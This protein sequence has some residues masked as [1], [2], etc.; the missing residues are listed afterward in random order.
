MADKRAVGHAYN[1]DFLNV[2]F[3][4]SSLFVLFT[5]V[6]MVWDDYDR[7]WKNHQREFAQ[8][9]MEVTRLNLGR[10]QQ[11]VDQARL[12]ELTA[13]RAAAEEQAAASAGQVADLETQLAE[14]NRQLFVATQ[15]YQ[16]TKANYDVDRY[17]FEVRRE[18]AH[19]EHPEDDGEEVVV[20]GEEE[21]T[22]LYEEWL[23][24]GLDVESLTASRDD[25]RRQIGAFAEGVSAI[26][27]E[28]GGLT[29]EMERLQGQVTD[30]QP[31]LVADYLLN[32]PLLDFMAP[33]L[34]VRQVIT[35]NIVD[36]VNFVRVAKMDRCETCHLAIDRVGYEDYPQ[37]F[38]THPELDAYVGSGSP[39]PLESTGCTVCH[40]GMGQS[41]SF[42][43]AAH[44]PAT[45]EQMALWEDEYDWEESHLWDFPMLPTGMAEASCAKCHKEELFVPGADNLNLAY[46]MYERAGCYAC[47]KTRGFEDLRK[48][49]PNLTKLASK[50][51]EE[52]VANWIRDPRAVKASTW[53][54]RVWYNSN[55]DAAEDAVRNEVEIDAV[56]AYLFAN[57]EDHEMAV[58]NP[59]R[60]DAENG[61]R[62]VD[63]VGCLACHITG[64]EGREAAG[65]RRTF[66]Q[67]LQAVGSKT[68]FEWL[69]DWVRDPRH[70]SAETYMPDLRLT[71][72]EIADVATYLAS[73]T[74]GAGMT[75]GAGYQAADVDAVLLDYMRAVVPSEEAQ[76]T[77]AAMS[78]EERQ[79]DLGQRAIGR[80]GCYSCHEISGFE[81]TQAIGTELSEEGSKLLPQFDFAF[82]HDIPHSKRD[83]IKAKLIDPRT[84][85]QNRILQPLEKLRMPDFGFSEEEA[86][87]LTTAVMSFQRDVQPKIAQVPRSARKDATIDGRNLLRRRNCVGC[88]EMEGDGGDYRELVEDPSL[89]PPL[90]TPEGA[91]VQADWLYDFFRGPITIRPWLDVRMPTFGLDDAHWNDFLDYFA[92]VSDV[93]GPF[94]THEAV[95]S[96]GDLRTGEELFELLRCQQCHVLD[97]IPED[98]EV[99]NLAPDLRMAPERLQPEWILNWLIDPLVIQPGT[100]MPG[101]WTEYPGS[102]YPQFDQDGPAQIQSIRDY[103]LTFSGGPSP[104]RGN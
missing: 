27:D 83:W 40:E 68:S 46:G 95:P 92:A 80:Y 70:Y 23:A 66:G 42:V 44:T 72:A 45:D 54:P 12:G 79:L 34:T 20:P 22:A 97:T 75:A 99:S 31:S 84:Y 43:D 17:A 56:V 90:L 2:V 71:D 16:F 89:A 77:L 100:R 96:A 59:R 41:I 9:E 81:D 101:F 49:G 7:E 14:V 32:A 24:L 15:R 18:A 8:I 102:F 38:R 3:A 82:V 76:A 30:L 74:G 60:G 57:S 33:T 5:T 36:D 6:W 39:H 103:L 11:D 48:P 25:L 93:V 26:D 85:D 29:G 86:R 53:M 1:I 35:P 37:P 67:P 69:Y 21:V 87:L 62:I 10:A 63:S 52:W 91:K 28:L 64:D 94:R 19:A 50:L 58:P 73:L 78:P 98:Q 51:D 4:A 88:H 65:P 13:Q 47:H 104:V 55:T 61:Q